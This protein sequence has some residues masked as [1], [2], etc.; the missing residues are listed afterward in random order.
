MKWIFY[1]VQSEILK[2]FTSFHHWQIRWG[3][4]TWNDLDFCAEDL[5]LPLLQPASLAALKRGWF[6]THHGTRTET[7]GNGDFTDLWC[8]LWHF[9]KIIMIYM[10][11]A[12]TM[13]LKCGHLQLMHRC[14]KSFGDFASAARVAIGVLAATAYCLR[15]SKRCVSKLPAT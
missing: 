7:T 11:T 5:V 8:S 15:R 14:A 1:R 12:L 4:R 2:L 13:P 9:F 10:N 6:G 3:H